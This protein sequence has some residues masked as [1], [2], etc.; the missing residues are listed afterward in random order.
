MKKLRPMEVEV[1]VTPMLDMAFQ[2]LTF[3]ILT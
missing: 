1:P 3:F 2:L